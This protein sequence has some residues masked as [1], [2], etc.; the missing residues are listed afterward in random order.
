MALSYIF[1]AERSFE[2][3]PLEE[4]NK[5][6]IYAS[7]RNG[8]PYVPS[9]YTL[10]FKV[11]YALTSYL[12]LTAGVDNITD[13]RYRTYSSGMAGAGRNF[14]LAVKATMY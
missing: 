1:N 6:F 13:Q 9:W 2:E 10:N 11:N 8:N 7:D 3:M 12:S 14:V 5:P 4:I